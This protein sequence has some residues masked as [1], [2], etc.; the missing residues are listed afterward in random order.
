MSHTNSNNCLEGLTVVI[1][2]FNESHQILD[3]L[4][5][6]LERLGAEVI[7][8]DDGSLTPYPKARIKIGKNCGYGTAIM[9]G[10]RHASNDVVMV[11]DGDGQHTVDSAKLLYNTWN[12]SNCD[13]IIAERKLSYEKF[14]RKFGRLTL[15]SIASFFAKRWLRDLNS[16]MRIFRKSIV[17]DYFQILCGTFSFTTSLTMSMLCDGLDVDW[18]VCDVK[19]RIFGKSKVRVIKHGLITLYY[20]VRI[21][22]A[23]RTRKFRAFL[24]ERMGR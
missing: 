2:E 5:S 20:I 24:R 12:Y 8:I 22:F 17:E 10:I 15:N 18:V 7:V 21:G 13:M 23:L 11:M 9:T 3:S 4:E 1:P 14:L 16:G 6:D 19:P